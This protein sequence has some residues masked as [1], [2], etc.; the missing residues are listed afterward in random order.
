MPKLRRSVLALCVVPLTLLLAACGSEAEGDTAALSGDPIDPIAAPDGASWVDT[1]ATTE[2]GGVRIGNP[3]APLQ[4]V[5]YASHT[6]PHCATFAET[7]AQGLDDYVAS[8]IVSYEL[9]NQIHDGLDL[10]IAMFVRCG[11]A[12]SFHPLARQAW[13]NLE[14]IVNQAQNNADALNAAMQVQDET[15]FQQIAQAAGLIDFFAARG[16]SRDQAMQCLA[17]PALAEQIVKSSQ[18]QSEEFD[19]T[20]TPTFFLNGRKLDAAGWAEVEA[21]LQRAGAR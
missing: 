9:R 13:A 19:I 6:C 1:A 21:A 2:M 16:I 11:E 5:E 10:T 3:A 12:S 17:K 7:S 14:Q 8:G 18:T 4:L 15:R 20:G